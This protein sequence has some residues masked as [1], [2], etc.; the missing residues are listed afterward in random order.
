MCLQFQPSMMSMP[1]AQNFAP[2]C[3]CCNTTMM[4][5]AGGMFPNPMVPA[6]APEEFQKQQLQFQHQQLSQMKINIRAFAESI[7]KSISDIE[8]ELKKIEGTK[9]KKGS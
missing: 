5:M 1:A 8:T 4:P 6:I 3:P 9:A 7:D 2:L